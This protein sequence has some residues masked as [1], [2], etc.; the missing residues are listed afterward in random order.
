MLFSDFVEQQVPCMRRYAFG[1]I[2]DLARA[3]ECLV[4]V[5]EGLVSAYQGGQPIDHLSKA[6]L[7]ARLQKVID[8]SETASVRDIKRKLILLL[9]MEQFSIDN[10]CVILN[11]PLKEL[12]RLAER[13]GYVI[14][15]R[16]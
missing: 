4:Q 2:E 9:E 11:V 5:L 12:L 1:M 8:E 7:F 14:N 10:V 15:A 13:E 6:D 3:D 16:T